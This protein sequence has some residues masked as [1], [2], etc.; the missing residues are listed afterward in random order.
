MVEVTKADLQKLTGRAP[1]TVRRRLDNVEPVRKTKRSAY[2]DSTVVI[3][4]M[5][6]TE[7]T[8]EAR[9]KRANAELAEARK[10]E[11]DLKMAARRGELVDRAAV[12]K[13]AHDIAAMT[14]KRFET[15]P[16]K[17]AAQLTDISQPAIIQGVL[18]EE[19]KQILNE[20]AEA[21]GRL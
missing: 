3:P 20:M 12:Q 4:L 10:A 16:S 21:C 2:Y 15:L 8:D 1:D 6:Y 7:E 14:R 9:L 19:V 5:Y 17:L 11:I 13:Q 18:L